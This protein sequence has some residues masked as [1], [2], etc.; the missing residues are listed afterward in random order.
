MNLDISNYCC[1]VFNPWNAISSFKCYFSV[2]CASSN[3]I[4]IT[5]RIVFL[6][7]KDTIVLITFFMIVFSLKHA[8]LILT[9][10]P[11]SRNKLWI[12]LKLWKWQLAIDCYFLNLLLSCFDCV[13]LWMQTMLY[14]YHWM[15]TKVFVYLKK[16]SN[17]G[18][19]REFV[20][21]WYRKG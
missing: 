18:H 12:I 13:L 21:E 15:E 20:E 1:N 5:F 2:V 14:G 19:W 6:V 8:H 16:R 7:P 10:V 3:D 17:F 4:F 11:V 9:M